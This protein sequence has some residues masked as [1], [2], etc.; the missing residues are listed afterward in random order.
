MTTKRK[1]ISF[2]GKNIVEAPRKRCT[3]CRDR[4]IRPWL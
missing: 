3:L 4:L 1:V 2:Y